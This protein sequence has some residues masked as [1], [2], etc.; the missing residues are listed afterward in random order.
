M[1]LF[2]LIATIVFGG[3]ALL[4]LWHFNMFGVF[5]CTVLTVGVIWVESSS[6][7]R[8]EEG[9]PYIFLR[10]DFITMLTLFVISIFLFILDINF[11]SWREVVSYFLS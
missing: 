3:A 9:G 1:G 10:A 11:D 5:V 2:S 6:A 4:Q 7:L 8:E